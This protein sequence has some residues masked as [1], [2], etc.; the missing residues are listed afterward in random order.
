MGVDTSDSAKGRGEGFLEV[1]EGR[2]FCP[3]MINDYENIFVFYGAISVHPLKGKENP[4]WKGKDFLGEYPDI[5]P[6]FFR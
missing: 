4:I 6:W 1:G 3:R 2:L 5:H